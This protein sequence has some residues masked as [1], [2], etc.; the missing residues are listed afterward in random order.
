[1]AAG[2]PAAASAAMPATA[3]HAAAT[4]TTTMSA[5]FAFLFAA[6]LRGFALYSVEPEIKRPCVFGQVVH[7]KKLQRDS[8][9]ANQVAIV[10]VIHRTS[11]AI[12]VGSSHHFVF[13]IL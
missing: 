3:A 13:Y 12:S 7:M 11:Y 8:G 2:R 10:V 1:M 4:S 6:F 9:L 5:A